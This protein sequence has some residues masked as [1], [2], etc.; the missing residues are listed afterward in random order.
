MANELRHK[1]TDVVNKLSASEWVDVDTHQFN[2]QATG[3]LAYAPSATQISRFPIGANGKILSVASGLPA[4]VVPGA[5]GA[6]AYVIANDAPAAIKTWATILQTAGFPVWGCDG[7]ADDVQI[8]AAITA[9]AAGNGGIVQ[10][11]DGRFTLSAPLVL[12]SNVWLRGN[13]ADK[14]ITFYV[15]PPSPLPRLN[16]GTVLFIDTAAMNAIN[17]AGEL[18]SAYL[19]DFSIDF[20]NGLASTGHGINQTALLNGLGLTQFNFK[21]ILANNV[22]KDHYSLYMETPCLGRIEDFYSYGGGYIKIVLT[23]TNG[24]YGSQFNAGNIQFDNCFAYVTTATMTVPPVMMGWSTASAGILNLMQFNR[25]QVNA[26]LPAGTDGMQ[27]THVWYTGFYNLD[28]EIAGSTK[29]VA[30]NNSQ[31]VAFFN[32]LVGGGGEKFEAVSS[33]VKAYGG[34]WGLVLYDDNQY[35]V[36]DGIYL[37]SLH[38]GSSAKPTHSVI[39]SLRSENSG[40]ATILDTTT[41]IKVT[42]GLAAVPT[43]VIITLTTSLGDATEIYVSNKDIDSDGL[44]FQVDVDLDPGANVSFDWR[45]QV[46]E[47]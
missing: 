44:K 39:N 23:D 21:N 9:A 31:E 34:R 6:S 24:L 46:G 13:G 26:T 17:I 41:S 43:R 25:F 22:D 33:L 38:A 19:S 16:N 18:Q 27:L 20:N 28:L 2:N 36:Y 12:A 3:D 47:G 11:S 32:P 14:D 5:L 4:W 37:N 42:H 15:T 40:T 45:A 10:L 29:V 1:N 7:T 30:L 35:S 8:Q